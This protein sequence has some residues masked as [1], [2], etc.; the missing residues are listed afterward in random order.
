MR[1][2]VAQDGS[3]ACLQ[4]CKYHEFVF[5]LLLAPAMLDEGKA[6]V[7]AEYIKA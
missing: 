5:E 2:Y 3:M 1:I 6:K 7:M 4:A